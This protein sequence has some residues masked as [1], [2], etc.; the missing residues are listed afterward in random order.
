MTAFRRLARLLPILVAL[1]LVAGSVASAATPTSPAGPTRTVALGVSVANWSSVQELERFA[2]DSGRMPA[3]WAVWQY[4]TGKSAAF[5]S[6]FVSE[7]KTRGVTPIVNWMPADQNNLENPAFSHAAIANGDHD[8]FIRRWAQA[9]KDSGVTV[10]LRFAHEAGGNWYPWGVG[11][12]GNTPA[13]VLASWRHVWDIFRGPDGVGAT[14]VKFVWS[15]A[16]PGSKRPS[17]AVMYPGDAY[18]DYAAFTSYNWNRRGLGWL[19]IPQLYGPTIKKIREVSKKP[20]IVAETGSTHIGGDKAAWITQGYT[21][22]FNK[23]S[24]IK[25]IVYFNT[26]AR[27][28]H[29]DWRLTTPDS[30]ME[31]YRQLL[32]QPQFQGRF[33]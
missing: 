33:Q 6:A 9:A 28:Q 11:R 13:T 16:S 2:A 23:W 18:V 22:A 8:A 20:L 5:P 32:T 15:P 31:A 3:V 27:P 24:G 4:W 26:D 14:N 25:A 1:P 29:R 30:A 7:L 21:A 19:T 12:L 17:Y 10:L